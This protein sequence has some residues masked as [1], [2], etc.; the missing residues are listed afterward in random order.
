MRERRTG[1]KRNNRLDPSERIQLLQIVAGYGMKHGAQKAFADFL[2]VSPQRL[3]MY[4]RGM[5]FGRTA[6]D[7][8]REK[9]PGLP[10]GWIRFGEVDGL[11]VVWLRQLERASEILRSFETK[12]VQ[13]QI[14]KQT[15]VMLKRDATERH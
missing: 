1:P 4:R 3:Q 13:P 11:T 5:P 12:R 8:I 15:V 2:G 14:K 9:F 10:Q 6:V 7:T